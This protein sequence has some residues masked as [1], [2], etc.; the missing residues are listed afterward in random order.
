MGP[1]V[2]LEG[3]ILNVDWDGGNN[4]TT[5][6]NNSGWAAIAGVRVAF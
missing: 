5:T 1:G 2:T 3:T 4:A 6:D